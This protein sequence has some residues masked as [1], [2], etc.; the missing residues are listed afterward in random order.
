M[1]DGGRYLE[2]GKGGVGNNIIMVTFS[3]THHAQL[4]NKN[5]AYHLPTVHFY[6][7]LQHYQK[8][9]SRAMHDENKMYYRFLHEDKRF[10]ATKDR[11]TIRTDQSRCNARLPFSG[12]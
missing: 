5:I 11:S 10:P 9:H 12:Y 2:G 3:S 4:P 1:D 6:T 7:H 8:E